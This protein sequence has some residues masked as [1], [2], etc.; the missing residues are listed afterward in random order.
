MKITFEEKITREVEITNF[1]VYRKSSHYFYK[2]IDERRCIAVFQSH[3]GQHDSIEASP[4]SLAF[5]KGTED[6]SASEYHN[7]FTNAV[8]NLH[9]MGDGD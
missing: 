3:Q 2:V 7:A 1:P 8:D 6:S 9:S 4:I 5:K